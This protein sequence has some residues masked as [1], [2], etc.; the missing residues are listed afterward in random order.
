MRNRWIGVMLGVLMLLGVTGCG[1]VK[2]VESEA[3]QISLDWYVNY[4]WFATPWGGNVVS[5]TITEETGVSVNFISPIGNETEKLNALIASDTLPDIITLGYWEPQV[6][7]MIQKDMVYAL[8]ELADEYEPYFWEVTDEAAI[9]W[10]T[11]ADGNIYAYPNSS[12]SPQDLEENSY[13]GSNQTFLVRKDIYEAIGSPDMT[14]REGFV[15]AV[16]KAASMFPL[17]D[18]KPLIP[19]GS[20]TF[21]NEGNVSFDKYLMNFLAIPWEKNGELYD[22]YTD[23]EY[24]KWLKMFRE[25]NEKGLLATDIFVDTRTQMEEKLAEGRYFCMIY[26][27]TDMLSQ[28]KMLYEADANKIYIAVE[29]P[30]NANGDEPTLPCNGVNGWTLTMISKNCENPDKAIE[31]IS[32]LLSEQGQLRTYLGVEGV[33]YDMVEGKP[34]WKSE[35]KELLDKDREAFDQ[36]YGADNTYWMFQDTVMQQKWSQEAS[37]AE[38]Q[39]REWSTKYVVYNGPYE[40][41]LPLGNEAASTDNRIRKLWSETLPQLLRA[42][43]EEAFDAIMADFVAKREEIGFSLYMKAATEYMNEAKKKLGLME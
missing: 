42:E 38:E 6:D 43:S 21:D 36:R 5:D 39:L 12:I 29:G 23:E 30:R 25:L 11:K 13:I 27:Y 31:F 2:P 7:E 32:Y 8:N 1:E 26:Q 18:G 33:T 34:V 37:P 14:T 10:Y 4:S 40:V 3:T 19:V 20:H 28:Q 22:R 41:Y 15:A 24:I 17:V 9:N 35:V 16:E